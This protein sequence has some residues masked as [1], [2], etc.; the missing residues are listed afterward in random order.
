MKVNNNFEEKYL[1]EKIV[2]SIIFAK[3]FWNY[4]FYH[5][6]YYFCYPIFFYMA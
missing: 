3:F 5:G 4:R 2:I 6:S 1:P